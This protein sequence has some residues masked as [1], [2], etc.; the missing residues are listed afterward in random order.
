M[1]PVSGSRAFHAGLPP[2][3]A[4]ESRLQVYPGLRHEIFNEPERRQVWQDILDWMGDP[5]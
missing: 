4:D 2:T 3:I 1:S 5:A